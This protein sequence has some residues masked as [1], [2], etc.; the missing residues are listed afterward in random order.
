MGFTRRDLMVAAAIPAVALAGSRP[1]A[2]RSIYSSR[3]RLFFRHEAWGPRGLT[4]DE[5]RRGG[6]HVAN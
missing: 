4:V 6:R 2:A 5:V 1:L 3:P